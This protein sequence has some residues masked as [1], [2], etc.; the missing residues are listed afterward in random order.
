MSPYCIL[1][2]VL[3]ILIPY[4]ATYTYA[5]SHVSDVR[6]AVS[7]SLSVAT[8]SNHL[9][10]DQPDKNKPKYGSRTVKP[11]EALLTSYD[12]LV[13]SAYVRHILLHT[14]EMSELIYKMLYNSTEVVDF[15]SSSHNHSSVEDQSPVYTKGIAS[16]PFGNLANQISMCEKSKQEGG[17]LGWIDNPSYQASSD[18]KPRNSYITDHPLLPKEAIHEIFTRK[19]K[20]GD[21]LTVKSN[22]GVHLL[23]VE[24][25][26]VKYRHEGQNKLIKT[27]SKFGGKGT[28]AVAPSF[29]A[30]STTET[31]HILTNGCQMNVADSERMEGVLSNSLNLSPSTSVKD[32]NVVVINT[33]SIRD[34]AESKLYDQL[35]PLAKRKRNGE[36]LA[37]IVTGCVAQQ[38]GELL[39]RKFPEVDAILGPQ[40]VNRLGDILQDVSQGH[41]VI[42]TDPT[43]IMEDISRPVRSSRVR[44]WVN[45]I[46]GC[47]EHCTYCVVPFTRGVEQSR[48]MEAIASEVLELARNGYK[49]VTLLG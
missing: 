18:E 31:Y 37:L 11:T 1:F 27:R 9:V 3:V 30:D 35:G 12:K 42:A 43:L 29:L 4:V 48:P 39:L 34:H 47:N 13:Q 49:E 8:D 38:E 2:P 6:L 33:C 26:L 22:L 17:L 15:L 24:D 10:T 25:V 32:A 40:Y 44:A 36:A 7:S 46:Y 5:F 45:V 28:A 20:S 23:R 41:Q 19:P 14:E 21:V 16:D